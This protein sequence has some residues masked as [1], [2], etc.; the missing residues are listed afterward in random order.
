MELPDGWGKCWQLIL[1]HVLFYVKQK[2]TF[3]ISC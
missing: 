3:T 2:L 1:S